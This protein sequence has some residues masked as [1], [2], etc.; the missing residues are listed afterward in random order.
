M[1]PWCKASQKHSKQKLKIEMNQLE[2]HF[3]Q[4]S[5]KILMVLLF[6]L[7]STPLKQL[8]KDLM[9]E[10]KEFEIRQPVITIACKGLQSS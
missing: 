7:N 10:K 8:S 5:L 6:F 1:Q 9:N 2:S 4:C 3:Y